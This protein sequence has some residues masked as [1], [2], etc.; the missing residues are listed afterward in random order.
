MSTLKFNWYE[1]C[2][3]QIERK[4]FLQIKKNKLILQ[5]YPISIREKII[6]ALLELYY[7]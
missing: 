3:P 6:Y 7:T 2:F 1:K 4:V 5:K